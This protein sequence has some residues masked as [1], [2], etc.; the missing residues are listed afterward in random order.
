MRMTRKNVGN[1]PDVCVLHGGRACSVADVLGE[2]CL[3][4]ADDLK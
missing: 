4:V 2:E 1:E 3:N